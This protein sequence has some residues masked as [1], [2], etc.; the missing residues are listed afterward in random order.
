MS[1]S[2]GG[3]GIEVKLESVGMGLRGTNPGGKSLSLG[4]IPVI[5]SSSGVVV[6]VS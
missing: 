6:V 2:G 3:S 1:N 4:R 5:C